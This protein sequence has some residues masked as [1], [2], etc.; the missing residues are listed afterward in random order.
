LDFFV[1]GNDSR[2]AGNWEVKG[3]KSPILRILV[4]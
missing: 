3:N 1:S 2:I 4:F